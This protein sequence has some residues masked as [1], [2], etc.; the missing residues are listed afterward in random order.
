MKKVM[1]RI[2]G[3]IIIVGLVLT[4]V[5]CYSGNAE[6][7]DS[8]QESISEQH[9]SSVLEESEEVRTL[10]WG[11]YGNYDYSGLAD[12]EFIEFKD[13]IRSNRLNEILKSRG[14]NFEVE[15]VFVAGAEYLDQLEL[16]AKHEKGYDIITFDLCGTGAKDLEEHLLQLDQYMDDEQ[17]LADVYK[18]YSEEVWQ[19]NKVDDHIYNVGELITVI[20]PTYYYETLYG[21]ENPETLIEVMTTGDEERIADTVASL[22][23]MRMEYSMWV[24]DIRDDFLLS[25]QFHMIAPGVGFNLEGSGEFENVYETEYVAEKM[26]Q[27]IQWAREGTVDLRSGIRGQQFGYWA[28]VDDLTEI[29]QDVYEVDEEYTIYMGYVPV[30][31]QSKI[32]PLMDQSYTSIFKNSDMIEESLELLNL[33]NTDQEA[34]SSIYEE[35]ERG[36]GENP[37]GEFVWLCNYYIATERKDGAKNQSERAAQILDSDTSPILGFCFDRTPVE[38]EVYELEKVLDRIEEQ[39]REEIRLNK[40]TSKRVEALYDV[41]DDPKQYNELIVSEAEARMDR[42]CQALKEAGIDTVIEEANRQLAEWKAN[43]TM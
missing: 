19:A 12:G 40:G 20:S 1:S 35:P 26:A 23:G 42:Y 13:R 36:V 2:R 5:A 6:N 43:N 32:I 4:V 37:T 38:K 39:K 8:K 16:A 31:D 22:D 7:Q 17:P 33:L 30:V 3:L 41:L 34:C 28:Y 11:V 18:L 29:S 15:I 14:L 9:S 27:Q 24:N 21:N 25:T 10:R